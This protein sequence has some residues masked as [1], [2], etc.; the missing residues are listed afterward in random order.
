MHE[1]AVS[2]RIGLR[3]APASAEEIMVARD[4]LITE[5]VRG[6]LHLANLSTAGSLDA[7]RAAKRRGTEISCDVTPHHFTLTDEDVAGAVYDPNY[8][9]E[10]PLRPAADREA[11]LQAI[12]DGTVDAIATDHAP[13]HADEKE[14]D[15]A[16]APAGIIGLETAVG[17]AVDRLLHAKVIGLAQLV[18]L[19]STGPAEVFNLPGG[20]LRVGERADVTLLDLRKR[21]TVNPERFRS[22]A[23]NTPFAGRR[24]KGVAVMTIVGGEI[25]WRSDR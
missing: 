3:G 19:L 5:S 17:L 10:P 13:H 23:R 2:T 4:T 16:D 25:V 21:W 14:L 12:Y 11:V 9:T 20:S 24:L 6:R 22:K 7:V 15:F 1:G 18:R 8:K